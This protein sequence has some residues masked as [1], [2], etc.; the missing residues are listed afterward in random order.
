M[1]NYSFN[2]KYLI[3]ENVIKD[4]GVWFDSKSNLYVHVNKIKNQTFSRLKFT[5]N[6]VVWISM[7]QMP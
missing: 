3:C 4:L 2:N 6:V 5:K 1:F 7:I